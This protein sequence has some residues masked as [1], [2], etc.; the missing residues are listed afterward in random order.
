VKRRVAEPRRGWLPGAAGI[1][2]AIVVWL[3]AAACSSGGQ[4]TTAGPTPGAVPETPGIV[5][6]ATSGTQAARRD[7]P[8]RTRAL[9]D[10]RTGETF[11]IADLEGKLVAIEPMAIWCSNCRIQQ[12]EAV[13]ALAEVDSDDL[14][15][16]GID[17]DPNERAGDLARYSREEGFDW[18][19]VVASRELSRE[20][21]DAFGPQ[22]L[23]PPST[24]TIL[25]APDGE[26]IEVHF[27]IRR[28]DELVAV[29]EA[30]LP[31]A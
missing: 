10:V 6:P 26:V 17:V 31:A 30:H 25:I 20:L 27:G 3:V 19:F 15:Y 18:P 5:A 2:V 29:F 12:R 22:V 9:E 14:V 4:G 13:A 8:W 28:A 1:A 7:E 24:P 23:S 21:A 11:A 16:I